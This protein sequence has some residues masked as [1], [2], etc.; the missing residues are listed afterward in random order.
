M[1]DGGTLDRFLLITEDLV[2]K[3]FLFD[4][5]RLLDIF[6][7]ANYTIMRLIKLLPLLSIFAFTCLEGANNPSHPLTKNSTYQTFKNISLPIDANL[8]NTIFQDDRG[9]IWL[10][11]KRGLYSY[12]GFDLHE[13]IDE[14]YP[15]GNPVFSIVQISNDYLCLGTDNGVRWFNLK[16]KTIGC[17][18]QTT[19]LSLA[20]RSLALYDNYLWIGTRDSGLK[21]MSLSTGRVETVGLQDENETTIYYLEAT[22]EKLFIAS[23]EHLSYYDS[24]DGVRQV[25]ELGNTE[26]LMVNSLLWDK[27]RDCIWVGTEGYL[28]KYD[29]QTQEVYRQSF[30]TG[31]SFKSLS[32]DSEDDLLIGTD[33]GLFVYDFSDNTHTQIVHDSRN[34]R[35]LCNNIIWDILC[36]KNQ[37]V[38]LATDRG[39][40]LAQT[41]IGQHYIH[42][43]E[44]VQSGDGNLFTYMMIDSYGDYWLGG[45][46]GLIHINN[47]APYQV[48]WFRQDSDVYPLR[49]NRIRH[50]Y[51][52][53]SNDIWIASDGGVGRYDRRNSKFVFYQIQI[54]TSGKNANWAYSILEDRLG[55]LWIASYMGGLFICN[56]DNLEILYH[57]DE[58]SG[59]GPN[60]YLMQDGGDYIWANTSNGLV[61]IDIKTQDV[62]RHEIYADNMLYHNNVIWYSILGRLYQYDTIK[63]ENT[64]IP[65]SETC[66][67]I[68]SLILENDNVWVTSSEGILCIDSATST[69]TTISSVTD[70]Y[71]CGIYDRQNREILLGGEDCLTRIDVDR[72]NLGVSS[73]S[74]F[75]ASLVSEGRLMRPNEDYKIA[76]N[77]IKINKESD[78][79]IE[80]SSFSYQ[81]DESYH[82]RFH[83]EDRWQSL[84]KGNNHISLVNLSGG[85]YSLQL[86]NSNPS[87][88]PNALV[89]EYY[90]TVPHPWYLRWPAFAVYAVVFIGLIIISIR[91]I[92]LRNRRKFELREKERSLELSNMKMDFFVN[93]SHELKTPLSLIIAPVSRML[94]ETTNARQRETLSTIHNNALRL[95]TLIHKVLNFKQLEAESEDMLIRSHTEICT[96][97]NNCINTFSAVIE[98]K[99]IAVNT[100]VPNEMIWANIDALK[101]E[102]AIIN[103]LSNAIKYVSDGSGLVNIE[104]KKVNNNAVITIA[105]NGRGIDKNELSLV[106]IRYFQGRNGKY[107]EGSGIGLYLVKKYIELHGGR[108]TIE[109]NDGTTVRLSIPLGGDNSC[110]V[111]DTESESS[112]SHGDI[113][114]RILIIDDNKE[115]VAFLAET[116]SQHYECHKAY[117]G[118][119]GLDV[120]DKH[121]PDLIIVDQMMPQMDGVT[122][123]RTIRRSY[124]TATTPII[125][126]TAREDMNTEMES[127]KVGV[128]IFMPKPFDIKKLQLRIAQLLHKRSSIEEAA[129]IE[130]TSK[131]DFK[132][133][134]DLRSPDEIFM[135]KV[136]KA[137]EENMGKEDFN[138]SA[139]ADI[140]SVDNKQL[141]RKLKQLTGSTPVNYIRKLRMRKASILLE[142][143]KFTVSE[144]MFI[145]GYSNPS[146]FSKCFTEEFGMSPKDYRK[147]TDL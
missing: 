139:L 79:I 89:N 34:S 50:I 2:T 73:D 136:T 118:K 127:I 85:T 107:K 18:Y 88:N 110:D 55:R 78:I 111:S 83:N 62:K 49:H 103:I 26:R 69:S 52:D 21:R 28:Y 80:L 147:R 70:N 61:S 51:E 56:K 104:L 77:R 138:V 66:R 114:A 123:S 133:C 115:I 48:D 15:Y 67:Q 41:D 96:L 76:G 37:N 122:F 87:V 46:N 105:D 99:K 33:A 116:L 5:S 6:A 64:N 98:E 39:V 13:Y 144:I 54:A 31:N 68:H 84:G 81:D 142:E 42:L 95:N 71:L 58:D 29:I 36:D 32:L 92:H 100:L 145:V 8:V 106:F 59:I 10:G 9:M 119:E 124:K 25:V 35:S 125:M 60:V 53:S 63:E 16:D 47:T 137:I 27:E 126:L 91:I 11:T 93:I 72:E 14:V 112:N 40:S 134:R 140:V 65:F 90:I 1:L 135:E 120:I 43:S 45:E 129:R 23:Y 131:P 109:S 132:E 12:N 121:T 38:W 4:D 102:S 101:L 24:N 86:S 7:L 113:S 19:E 82:Y 143:D 108:I 74:V 97:L 75:I 146:Y 94:S 57:F 130:V 128:D 22:E 44:I 3:V 20:V 17:L 30:L 141:Y 117:N